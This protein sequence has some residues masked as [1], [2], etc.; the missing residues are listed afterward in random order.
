MASWS[1]GGEGDRLLL[2][3]A[4]FVG[5]SV[6]TVEA[7]SARTR[8][9]PGVCCERLVYVG[10]TVWGLV[11]VDETRGEDAATLGLFGE[12]EEDVAA[13]AWRGRC[14]FCRWLREGEGGDG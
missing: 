9:W 13:V 14:E 3:W 8:S 4:P 2:W 7:R 11:A 1:A 10:A 6:G 12:G 5:R